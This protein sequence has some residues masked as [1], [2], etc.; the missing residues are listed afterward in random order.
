LPKLGHDVRTFTAAMWQLQ[1]WAGLVLKCISLISSSQLKST[2]HLGG[3]IS[4]PPTSAMQTVGRYFSR[5]PFKI[6]VLM[7]ALP[8]LIFLLLKIIFY[9]AVYSIL[10]F[11]IVSFISNRSRISWLR[12]VTKERKVFL[13]L[14]SSL[15][16][17]AFLD[18][19]FLIGATPGM[20]IM[21]EFP[22][23]ITTRYLILMMP[24]HS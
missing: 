18:I 5:Q 8:G 4:N 12:K 23:V 15:S 16:D 21:L 24:R 19:P 6:L 14:H 2:S 3:R 9:S 10:L 11:L 13:P 17:L 1:L 7:F 22:L 20:V